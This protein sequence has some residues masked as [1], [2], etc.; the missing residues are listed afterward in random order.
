MTLMREER[1]T[2]S[3][4]TRITSTRLAVTA[5]LLGIAVTLAYRPFSQT[6]R[7]DCGIYDYIAQSILRGQLPYRDVID[8]KAPVSMYLSA[9]AIAIGR[10]VGAPDVPA[11]RCLYVLLA[12]LLSAITFLTA[13][14][15]LRSRIAALI[16]SLIPLIPG[17]FVSMMTKGT[18]P[19]VPMM[20]FGMLALLLVAK[21]RPFWA[22]FCSMLSCLCWQPGLLFAGTAFLV[23][24]RY[25]TSWRDWRVVKLVAGATIPLVV[26]LL[27]FYSRGALSDLWS[28]TITYTFAVFRPDGQKPLAQALAQIWKI[29]HREFGS[30]LILPGLSL[31]GFAM[32]AA[33]RVR[34]KLQEGLRS[35]DLFRDAI[36]LPPIV[37]F[38]FCI[39][40][41]QGG[42]D[43]IPF[44]PFIGLFAGW[45]LVEIARLIASS[46]FVKRIGQGIRWDSLVPSI[47]MAAMLVLILI[48][49]TSY[50]PPSVD[51]R[52][53]RKAISQIADYLGPDDRIYVHG[54][55]EI[56]VLLNV[57]NLNRYIAF[58][59]G[60]DD[61]IGAQRAGGFKDVI[62][63]IESS[64]PK[65]VA[66]SRLRNV[67]H[68]KDLEQWVDAHYDTLE[69]P[70][71]ETIYI[72]KQK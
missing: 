69:L 1:M 67:R 4:L 54:M 53:Q 50:K 45:S 7:G 38:L 31:I 49:T 12:G 60:A 37:Y 19:K 25:L 10:S 40:D 42:P 58:D 26:V 36:L 6:V 62:A 48:R 39:L 61:Y 52:E 35:V 41:F 34:V 24:S 30:D 21:D 5:F 44:L 18:Q 11:V 27:Y 72:R 23:F 51:L 57:P 64:A 59:S 29:A 20:I 63:E 3:N 9:V 22:G 71:C 16:A 43:L 17:N 8:P 55:A 47:A 46:G 2:W 70:G 68:G 15:Y 28:W 33:G 14:A 66:M 13:E 56:L 65:L 32:Y